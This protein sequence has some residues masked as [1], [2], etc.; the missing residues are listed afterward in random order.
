MLVNEITEIENDESPNIRQIKAEDKKSSMHMG[1]LPE[2]EPTHNFF[3]NGLSE[4]NGPIE[5]G[6]SNGFDRTQNFGE[7]VSQGVDNPNSVN[8]FYNKKD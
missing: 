4:D 3:P 2:G 7:A 8:I 6:A 5:G 1:F